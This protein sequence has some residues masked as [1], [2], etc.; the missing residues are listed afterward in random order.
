MHVTLLS[1]LA[2]FSESERACQSNLPLSILLT[3]SYPNSWYCPRMPTLFFCIGPLP[4]A[5]RPFPAS[6]VP[7]INLVSE[8]KKTSSPNTAFASFA[9]FEKSAKPRPSRS[10]QNLLSPAC[11]MRTL[12]AAAPCLLFRPSSQKDVQNEYWWWDTD[13]RVC[14]GEP[15]KSVL[16]SSA[17]VMLRT[18]PTV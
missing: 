2:R 10:N 9:S 4:M 13:H 18:S 6:R 15:A 16:V 5:R 17:L 11:R 3:D 7:E 1:V 14:Q 8:S 12:H